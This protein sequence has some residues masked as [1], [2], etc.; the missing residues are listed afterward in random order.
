MYA[1][2]VVGVEEIEVQFPLLVAQW[3]EVARREKMRKTEYMKLL[4]EKES[5]EKELGG[6][7]LNETESKEC[8][9]NALESHLDNNVVP[10]TIIDVNGNIENIES[11]EIMKDSNIGVGTLLNGNENG[12]VE[13]EIKGQTQ[14]QEQSEPNDHG[15]LKSES[16]LPVEPVHVG[17]PVEKVEV[18]LMTEEAHKKLLAEETRS[19]SQIEE[20]KTKET[21]FVSQPQSVVYDSAKVEKLRDQLLEKT[22]NFKLTKL[23]RINSKLFDILWRHR[24][25][26]DKT[27]LLREL[28]DFIAA[29]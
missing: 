5:K 17:D 16:E 12:H 18:E 7:E 29:L 22:S 2:A 6:K 21:A 25:N 20:E 24:L 23:E 27:G 8:R 4:Q 14:V 28:D 19:D 3:K 13:Y 15:V 1:H 11:R 9:S 10:E 26:L